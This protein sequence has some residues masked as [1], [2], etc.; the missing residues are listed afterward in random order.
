MQWRTQGGGQRGPGPPRNVCKK[1]FRRSISQK[2]HRSCSQREICAKKGRR[3]GKFSKNGR[4]FCSRRKIFPKRSPKRQ[5]FRKKGR[6]FCS[7][8]HFLPK[9]VVDFARGENFS[10]KKVVDFVREENFS[11]KKSSNFFSP[12]LAP[13]EIF[14]CVRPW[15]QLTVFDYAVV[16]RALDRDS[17]RRRNLISYRNSRRHRSKE[18]T[19]MIASIPSTLDSA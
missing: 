18:L 3:E 7:R 2:S 19:R 13:P 5:I 6:K 17:R 12:G 4:Q 15:N 1:I 14:F 9:K 8:R 11:Q 16:Q 10:Q